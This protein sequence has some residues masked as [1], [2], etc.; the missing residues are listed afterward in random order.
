M[1]VELELLL[2]LLPA[3]VELGVEAIA[4]TIDE[5]AKGGGGGLI[6]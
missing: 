6:F 2:L 4:S 3:E 5:E 1:A